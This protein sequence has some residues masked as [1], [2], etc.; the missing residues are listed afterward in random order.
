MNAPLD[1]GAW[2]RRRY[3]DE[4]AS[5][6]H[7][8]EPRPPAS[9]SRGGLGVRPPGLGAA[10]AAV[11]ERPHAGGHLADDLAVEGNPPACLLAVTRLDLAEGQ[12]RVVA[13]HSADARPTLGRRSSGRFAPVGLLATRDEWRAG[14]SGR[15]RG[16]GR[17]RPRSSGSSTTS[18]RGLW[19]ATASRSRLGW[20]PSGTNAA[21]A[22][23][24][25]DPSTASETARSRSPS[26]LRPS[27]GRVAQRESAR[28]TR[29]RSLVRTQPRP[30]KVPAN[31]DF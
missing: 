7:W 11:R 15:R 19:S 24:G 20:L 9:T 6:R 14:T 1:D 16:P 30:S 31:I 27:P 28:L 2:R 23:R 25:P 13:G 18:A 5:T 22:S 26:R 4:G 12:R 3:L 10:L 21:A 8:S 29:E 17:R